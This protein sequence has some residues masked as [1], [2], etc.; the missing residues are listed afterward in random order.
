MGLFNVKHQ[1]DPAQMEELLK[2]VQGLKKSI[3]DFR[4]RLDKPSVDAAAQ[5]LEDVLL[6][7][8]K[9]ESPKLI[10]PS[11]I[12]G[13][14]LAMGQAIGQYLARPFRDET[15]TA[16]PSKMKKKAFWSG[17]EKAAKELTYK[18]RENLSDAAFVFPEKR[19]YPI[20]DKAHA[21]NAL[22]R[23]SQFGSPS[24]QKAVRA[25]VHS[26]FPDIGE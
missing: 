2:G 15:P 9:V 5:R 19:K 20:H 24:E 23:V 3:G 12:L 10:M 16:A 4:I 6:K 21:R 14:S 22:A 18:A 7:A 25:A 8:R 1:M 13:G 17:F 26:K 11:I